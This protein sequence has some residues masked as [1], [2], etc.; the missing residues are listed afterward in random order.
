[1]LLV[2][3]NCLTGSTFPLHLVHIQTEFNPHITINKKNLG[4][5]GGGGG[6][7]G[8]RGGGRG[9][10]GGGEIPGPNPDVCLFFAF[11]CGKVMRE[12]M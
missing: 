10:G 1:M 12:G 9:G 5:W 2:L 6:G 11:L 4:G 7:G 8:G 3:L